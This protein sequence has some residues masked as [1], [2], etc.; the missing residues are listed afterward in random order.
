MSEGPD[1][2][3]RIPRPLSMT[4]LEEAWYRLFAHEPGQRPR[5]EVAALRA[6]VCGQAHAILSSGLRAECDA[7][8]QVANEHVRALRAVYAFTRELPAMY[9]EFL[10]TD[11]F[12]YV[13]PV[14]VRMPEWLIQPEN[15]DLVLFAMRGS[16]A[17]TFAVS[18]EL[19]R[20][21]DAKVWAANS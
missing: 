17:A 5:E 12:L 16:R 8:L 13:R 20:L 10:P 7:L 18:H 15:S 3:P 11:D 2:T 21:L 19:N 1:S 14:K 4:D 6:V 9:L